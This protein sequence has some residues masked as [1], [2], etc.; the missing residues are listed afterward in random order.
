[1]NARVER[2]RKPL[3]CP[4]CGARPMATIRYG[5]QQLTPELAEELESGRVTLGGCCV[6]DDDPRWECSECGRLIY[7][8]VP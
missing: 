4:S 8:K 5:L 3:T 7:K 6:S 2:I 1:M